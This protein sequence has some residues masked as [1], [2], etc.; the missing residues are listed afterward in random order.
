M[1]RTLLTKTSNSKVFIVRLS[2]LQFLPSV[3][4]GQ[5]KCSACTFPSS[6]WESACLFHSTELY[7]H[8]IRSN[9][10]I[11]EMYKSMYVCLKPGREM[12]DTCWRSKTDREEGHDSHMGTWSH[13]IGAS[14]D[15]LTSIFF[16]HSSPQIICSQQ[17]ANLNVAE[18]FY[19]VSSLPSSIYTRQSK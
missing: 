6:S 15:W 17:L 8:P 7:R 16:L 13:K 14:I 9:S 18:F 11:G 10:E 19:Q 3:I 2:Q 1:Q 12:W 4:V 5:T